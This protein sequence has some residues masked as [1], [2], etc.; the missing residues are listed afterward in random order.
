MKAPKAARYPRISLFSMALTFAEIVGM[1]SYALG[2]PACHEL[3][4]SSAAHG[5]YKERP[6][7]GLHVPEHVTAHQLYLLH[8]KH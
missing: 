3:P 6:T 5:S 7:P 1:S 8:A 2:D 4:W